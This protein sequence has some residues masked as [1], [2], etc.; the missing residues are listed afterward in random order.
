MK[1][2][3]G[4]ITLQRVAP[5]LV[6]HY[7]VLC[8]DYEGKDSPFSTHAVYTFVPEQGVVVEDLILCPFHE[9]MLMEKM[10]NNWVKRKQRESGGHPKAVAL[11]KEKTDGVEDNSAP[12]PAD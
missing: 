7:C 4:T 5:S 1:P 6:E 2:E 10:I 11:R 8:G 12:N 9:V 3:P